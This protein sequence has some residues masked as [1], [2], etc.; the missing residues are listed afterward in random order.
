MSATVP[1]PIT[2][3]AIRAA[4]ERIKDSVIRTPLV[5]FDPIHSPALTQHPAASTQHPSVFLKL[6]LLQ[7]SGAFKL[8]GAMNAIRM[9]SK[10]Q[11]RDGVWTASS[12]NMAVA[13]SYAANRLDLPCTV[14]VNEGAP[15]AKLKAI[16][17]L[18]AR[19]VKDTWDAVLETCRTN[20]HKGMK[21]LFIHPF[22]DP[23]V[24]AGNATI[25]L[26]ILEDL[27]ET[28]AVLIPYGG[29][30]LAAAVASAIKALRPQAKC[31]AAEVE[32]GA[33][34]AA[35][36]AAGRPTTVDQ[37]PSWIS[38]IGAPFV[39]DETWPIVTKL[40]EGSIVSTLAD[41][42]AAIRLTAEHNHVIPEGAGAASIAG[43]F[44]GKAGNGNVVAL[45]T[46]GNIDTDK[47]I[48]ILQGGV[49]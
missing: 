7:P 4:R 36:W 20:S 48:K 8:R 22:A 43:A 46:G 40:L 17:T 34:A 10:S 21:G 16:E 15:Q 41:V 14:L 45:V 38:G 2:L 3:D 29:G 39:F 25:G 31:Y 26:E 49:P 33:P 47:V 12:G 30:G 9:A 37:K 13:V 28:D 1:Q 24:M 42:A 27:P 11:L 23:N 5:R 35:S 44:S 19:I 6:E 32:T 18:G